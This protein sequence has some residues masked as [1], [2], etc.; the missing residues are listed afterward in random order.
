M[1]LFSILADTQSKI[2]VFIGAEGKADEEI[3]EC[4][5]CSVWIHCKFVFNLWKIDKHGY[6]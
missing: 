1:Y 3:N 6:F 4:K 5:E 2:N